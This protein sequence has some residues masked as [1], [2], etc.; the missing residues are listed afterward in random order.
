M[1]S[2]D[3][4]PQLQTYVACVLAV[5]VMGCESKDSGDRTPVIVPDLSFQAKTDPEGEK[6]KL[7]DEAL[8]DQALRSHEEDPSH[9]HLNAYELE[10]VNRGQRVLPL[11]VALMTSDSLDDREVA[12]HLLE[13]ITI[14]AYGW[15]EAIGDSNWRRS[16]WEILWNDNGAYDPWDQL[17]VERERSQKLWKDFLNELESNK[18]HLWE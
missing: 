12:N 10:L 13:G 18:K 17:P 14:R 9:G 7:T 2:S 6:E 5:V 11:A 1:V 16:E 8:L 3:K 15:R 4:Y